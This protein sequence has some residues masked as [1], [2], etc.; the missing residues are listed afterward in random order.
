MANGNKLNQLLELTALENVEAQAN[1]FPEFQTVAPESTATP[2]GNLDELIMASELEVLKSPKQLTAEESFANFISQ[3]YGKTFFQK[4]FPYLEMMSEGRTQ[5]IKEVWEASGSPYVRIDPTVVPGR[6]PPSYHMEGRPN[7]YAGVGSQSGDLFQ[8]V[9]NIPTYVEE[10]RLPVDTLNIGEK[11]MEAFYAELAHAKYFG[12]D[13][14]EYQYPEGTPYGEIP[15]DWPDWG[16][17]TERKALEALAQRRAEKRLQSVAED[18]K[19]GQA[20]YDPPA[21]GGEPTVEYAAHD[22]IEPQLKALFKEKYATRKLPDDLKELLAMIQFF[23][24]FF[25]GTSQLGDK[26]VSRK[27]WKELGIPIPVP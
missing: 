12:P 3:W 10:E 6:K 23:A 16:Q 4:L 24:M 11:D 9:G 1:R 19:H 20:K 14:Y 21:P 15:T 17:P 26:E 13:L 5:S 18:I 7:Y 22:I 8:E 25:T 2:H 27:F